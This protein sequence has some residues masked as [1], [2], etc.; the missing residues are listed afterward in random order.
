[1]P[2]VMVAR[3]LCRDKRVGLR[4]RFDLVPEV[5]IFYVPVLRALP[6]IGTRASVPKRTLPSST[7]AR[8]AARVLALECFEDMAAMSNYQHEPER[9]M[10]DSG[11]GHDIVSRSLLSSLP[12]SRIRESAEQ[13]TISTANGIIEVGE[14]ALFR[15]PKIDRSISA[16]L[17]ESSPSVLSL[18][19]RCMHEGYSFRWDAGKVPVFT[20]PTGRAI[21]IEVDGDIP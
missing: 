9:W 4:V 18:G 16:L 14:E 15:I 10:L 6:S 20:S 2:F 8:R 21:P 13:L 3:K 19:K 12:N 1:M 17:L 5:I 7:E 11:S